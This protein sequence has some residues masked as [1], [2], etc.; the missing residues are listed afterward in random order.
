MKLP[1]D[2]RPVYPGDLRP[3][4]AVAGILNALT[5]GILLVGPPR[6]LTYY[7]SVTLFALT[8][9]G[10]YALFTALTLQLLGI[11]GKSGSSRY[12][13]ALSLG[14]APVSSMTKVDGLGPRFFGQERLPAADMP[15]SG[16]VAVLFLLWFWWEH[17]RV[18]TS[19]EIS[20]AG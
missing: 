18:N 13:I 10:C 7:A 4:Y 17:R 12:A 9:G 16:G 2:L 5:L 8:V 14:N 20:H 15:V 6:P 11:S 19:S 1:G 3:V